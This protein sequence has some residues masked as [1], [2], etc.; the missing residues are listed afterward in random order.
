M[1]VLGAVYATILALM[2]KIV[3]EQF[4]QVFTV[5]VVVLMDVVQEKDKPV[6][7]VYPACLETFQHGIQ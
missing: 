1:R 3:R 5:I 4:C 2:L 7:A 6:T